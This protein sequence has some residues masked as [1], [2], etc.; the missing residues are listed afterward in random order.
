[1]KARPTLFNLLNWHWEKNEYCMT[2]TIEDSKVRTLKQKKVN[3]FWIVYNM[4]CV[5]LSLEN[6]I[7]LICWM[8][9]SCH[10]AAK[11][12]ICSFMLQGVFSWPGLV[13]SS[14]ITTEKIKLIS[15]EINRPLYFFKTTHSVFSATQWHW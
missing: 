14:A 2:W 11:R 4:E 3:L 7:T 13:S 6:H 10:M 15:P 9:Y 12:S 1:M 5:M 8:L